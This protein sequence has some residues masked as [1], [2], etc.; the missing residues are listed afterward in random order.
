M[1]S[2]HIICKQ[3]Q[4]NIIIMDEAAQEKILAIQAQLDKEKQKVSSL[5][6][7]NRTLAEDLTSGQRHTGRNTI[8]RTAMDSYEKVNLDN[9]ATMLK[10]CILPFCKFFP[11]RW[12]TYSPGD[13][14]SLYSRM[15]KEID[16]PQDCHV[17]HY[18]LN[19]VVPL[20]NKKLIDY[21]SNATSMMRDQSLSEC[22]I[23]S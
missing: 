21:R 13:P 18:W 20:I 1:S 15:V 19:R 7:M 6:R 9:V 3:Q 22:L 11:E 8:K 10:Y 4:P 16:Y 2:P 23:L 12:Y 14:R 17:Q 5:Q